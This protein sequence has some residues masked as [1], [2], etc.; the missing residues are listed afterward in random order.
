MV[1]TDRVLTPL[2]GS[3]TWKLGVVGGEDRYGNQIGYQ[4]DSTVIG[5]SF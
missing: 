2:D 4:K 1:I 3:R 5:V